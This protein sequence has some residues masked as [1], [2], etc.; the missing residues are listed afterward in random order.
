[1]IALVLILV[2]AIGLIAGPIVSGALGHDLGTGTELLM[3]ISGLA[4]AI[5]SGVLMIVAKLYQKTRANEALVRTGMGGMKVIKDGGAIVIP[6]VHQLVR[7]PLESIRLEMERKNADGLITG[8]KLRA[9]IRAEFFVRVLPEDVDVM[10]ASR[11]LGSKLANTAEVRG[12]VEDKLVSALRNAAAKKTL[13]ELNSNRDS[14]M[15]EVVRIVTTDL[16]HNGLTLESVT[17]SKLD[18]ADPKALNPNN[19]FDAQGLRTIAEIVQTNETKRN[20]LVR[21]GERARTEQDVKTRQQVLA[22]EQTQA[23]AEAGQKAEI[24]KINAEKLRETQEKEIAA[25]K[26]IE[27]A[28]V[29]KAKALEVAEREK[30]KATEV[31]ERSKQEA[32]TQAEQ[33]VEVAK[34]AAEKAVAEAEADRAK[35]V[36]LQAAAEAEAEE[37][38]QSIKTVEVTAAAEREKRQKVIQAQAEAERTYVT[39]QRK[40]D[41]D[42]YATEKDAAARKAAADADAEATTKKAEAEAAA[43]RA[44][45]D[46]EASALESKAR[47]EKALQMVPVEVKRGEVE[48]EKSKVEVEQRRVEVLQQEL[49]ARERHGKVAQEFEIAKL[50][51]DAEARVRIAAS[52]AMA[53]LMGS[54]KAQVFGTAEDVAKMTGQYMRG[55]GLA[56]IAEGFLSTAGP[57]TSAG[58]EQIVGLIKGLAAKAGITPEQLAA[59]KVIDATASGAKAAA[60]GNG[61]TS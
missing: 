16:K 55:M 5:V 22:L 32:I 45:A 57:E 44:K 35:A 52:G 54:V 61:K 41:A 60:E 18:Q 28:G 36:A 39:A 58:V 29:E 2:F 56:N 42:A 8:D 4:L 48:V 26:A 31:A 3:F 14:F 38:R 47:G 13:E 1:M 11:S 12:L 37:K 10:N 49:E 21:E 6:V 27:L 43:H 23:E 24:A 40:A 9:D 25:A 30:Q 59:E 7:V 17:I 50:R 15:E 34:R 53:D 20:E 51:I 33:K 46:A 19:I